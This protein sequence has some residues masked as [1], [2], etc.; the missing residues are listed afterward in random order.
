[1]RKSFEFSFFLGY[2]TTKSDPP[3]LF[4]PKINSSFYFS[5]VTKRNAPVCLFISKPNVPCGFV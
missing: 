4:K 3:K 2:L 1:M 5:G